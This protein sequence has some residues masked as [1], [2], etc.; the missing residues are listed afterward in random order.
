[1]RLLL[2]FVGRIFFL[3]L[4]ALFSCT[5]ATD[6]SVLYK[7]AG[8]DSIALTYS[9]DILP[10]LNANCNYSECHA[11]GDELN[12]KFDTY[13]PIAL[14]ARSGALDFRLDLPVEDTRHMPK[15]FQLSECDYYKLKLWVKQGFPE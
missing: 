12:Y 2:I 8:C 7:P 6:I 15:G 11:T 10:I 9:H 14:Q 4:L 1:M 3:F 5:D 13:P